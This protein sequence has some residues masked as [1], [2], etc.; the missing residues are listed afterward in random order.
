MN[1]IVNESVEH[2]KFGNGKI[3]SEENDRVDVAFE[4]GL[5]KKSFQFPDAFEKFL[6]LDNEALQKEC[7]E[8]AVKKKEAIEKEAQEIRKEQGRME[9]ELKSKL[10]VVKKKRKVTKAVIKS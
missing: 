4:N 2:I 10:E 5:G 9:E 6:K 8:L 1:S 7:F 3:I